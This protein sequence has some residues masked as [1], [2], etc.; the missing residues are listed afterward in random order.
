MAERLD[1]LGV[2]S[3][4]EAKQLV[5]SLAVIRLFDGGVF[6]GYGNEIDLFVIPEKRGKWRIRSE[7][8]KFLNDMKQIHGKLVARIEND[9]LPSLRLA[10]HFGFVEYDK[11]VC[12]NG[13]FICLEK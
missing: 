5:E 13:I 8:T 3:S 12:D 9:N 6:I 11:E 2:D 10:K 4:D 1:K 7:T